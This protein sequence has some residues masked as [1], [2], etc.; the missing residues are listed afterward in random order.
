MM[1]CGIKIYF[2]GVFGTHSPEACSDPRQKK[3]DCW[4]GEC[5]VANVIRLE[6]HLWTD[7]NMNGLDLE[8][9]TKSKNKHQALSTVQR[10]AR[11][12]SRV[13]HK[14]RL[15]IESIPSSAPVAAVLWCGI[16]LFPLQIS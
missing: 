1:G 12:V 7:S 3:C 9:Q 6:F 2:Q 5:Y 11:G 8:K 10:L 15:C 14:I 13:S 4:Q 16:V